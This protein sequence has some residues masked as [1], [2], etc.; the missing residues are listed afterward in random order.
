M[1]LILEPAH[2]CLWPGI[3]VFYGLKE[4]NLA[5]LLSGVVLDRRSQQVDFIRFVIDCRE[6]FYR[7][8]L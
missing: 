3:K 4:V 2:R 5:L 1:E 6:F 8:L 7:E